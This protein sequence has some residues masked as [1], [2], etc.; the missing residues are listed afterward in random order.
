[1]SILKDKLCS[2]PTYNSRSKCMIAV[3]DQQV[4][5]FRLSYS[6]LQ[7]TRTVILWFQSETCYHTLILRGSITKNCNSTSMNALVIRNQFSV[8]IRNRQG[9]SF[10]PNKKGHHQCEEV[11]NVYVY[12]PTNGS[13]ALK[14]ITGKMYFHFIAFTRNEISIAM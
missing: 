8:L 1:M 13:L 7:L 14:C 2:R 11:R 9:D 3:F 4:D 10:L 5:V 12:L 6:V